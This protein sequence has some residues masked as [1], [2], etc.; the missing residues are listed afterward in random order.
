MPQTLRQGNDRAGSAP[1][2]V[3]LAPRGRTAAAAR[4]ADRVPSRRVRAM[5][6]YEYR[7]RACGTT[8]ELRRPMADSDA[9]ATCPAGHDDTTRLLSVFASV[10]G[11]SAATAPVAPAPSRGGCCGGACGCG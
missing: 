8:F 1:V 7:C 3:P 11:A 6:T 10:G 5:A 4:D 2:S 9:P